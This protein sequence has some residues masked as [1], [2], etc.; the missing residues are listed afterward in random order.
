MLY[1]IDSAQDFLQDLFIKII[2]NSNTFNKT[3][4]FSTWVYSIA[5]NMCKNEYRRL[6]MIKKHA[7]CNFTSGYDCNHKF[8]NEDLK[9][10]LFTMLGTLDIDKRNVFLLRFQE[11]Y[12][13]REIS[14]I[15]DCPEGTVKS[16]L[17]Y[18]IRYLSDKLSGFDPKNDEV[19]YVKEEN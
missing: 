11:E 14:K 4:K 18:A 6:N 7:T 3:K 15:M 9:K 12:S 10:H 5:Y 19:V 1:D 8:G 2:D 17:H 13:I 16:R